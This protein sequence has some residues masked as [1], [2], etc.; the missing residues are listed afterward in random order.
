MIF[1]RSAESHPNIPSTLIF[2]AE[3]TDEK[4]HSVIT[5]Q[6]LPTPE[7]AMEM[8]LCRC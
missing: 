6:L 1:K 7:A 4:Y 5:G 3:N 8:Q 2:G